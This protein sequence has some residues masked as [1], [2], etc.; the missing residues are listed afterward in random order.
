MTQ[1][2]N[3]CRPVY[4]RMTIQPTVMYLVQVDGLTKFFTKD[5]SEAFSYVMA[6]RAQKGWQN[7]DQHKRVRISME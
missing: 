6:L 1:S 2:Q 3:K 4:H 5:Y 7:I